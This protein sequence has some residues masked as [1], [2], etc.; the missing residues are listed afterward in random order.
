MKKLFAFVAAI[1][2][3][4]STLTA[5]QFGVVDAQRASQSYWKVIS[6]QRS[7]AQEEQYF[8]ELQQQIQGRVDQLAKDAQA[9]QEEA[10]NPGLSDERRAQAQRLAESKAQ[11]IQQQRMSFQAQYQRTM[12][13]FQENQ[14]VISAEIEASIR[15][16]ARKNNLDAVFMAS[17]APYAKIDITDEVIAD[18]NSSEP[19]ELKAPSAK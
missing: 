6:E 10:N 18:L 5:Q 19:A 14:E 15:K 13:R 4:A 7:A 9:A 2:L 12:R 16:V 8:K 17:V 1:A 3:A 11:E